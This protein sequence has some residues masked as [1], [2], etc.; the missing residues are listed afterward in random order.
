MKITSAGSWTEYPEGDADTGPLL[1]HCVPQSRRPGGPGMVV[2][3]QKEQTH[4]GSLGCL[5]PLPKNALKL[6]TQTSTDSVN[7]I[8]RSPGHWSVS[9]DCGMYPSEGST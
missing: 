2:C 3:G 9:S 1:I 6:T 8:L 4:L 7:N 5:F